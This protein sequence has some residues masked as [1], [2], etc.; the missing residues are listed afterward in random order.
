MSRGYLA[1]SI[2]KGPSERHD[3]RMLFTKFAWIG[4]YVLGRL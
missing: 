3:C 4:L 1:A 2:K